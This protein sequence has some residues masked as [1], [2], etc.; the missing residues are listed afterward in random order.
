M[1]QQERVVFRRQ[2]KPVLREQRHQPRRAPKVRG[3][4][5]QA[6]LRPLHALAELDQTPV[7]LLR[8]HVEVVERGGV[9]VLEARQEAL[10]NHSVL[11]GGTVEVLGSALQVSSPLEVVVDDGVELLQGEGL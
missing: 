4:H 7:G 3:A 8:H 1:R 5:R 9:A 2:L 11:V 6:P 10:F